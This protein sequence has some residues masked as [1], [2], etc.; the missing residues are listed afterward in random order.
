VAELARQGLKVRAIAEGINWR[1]A[2]LRSVAEKVSSDDLAALARIPSILELNLGSVPLRDG[3]LAS[4]AALK[5]LAVLH[6]ENTPIT[7]E[8]LAHLGRLEKLTYLNL[9]GTAVTD[10]G[11]RNLAGLKHLKWLYLAGTKVTG[12]GLSRLRQQLPNTLIESGAEFAEIAT[13]DPE[14]PNKPTATPPV[15]AA[16]EKP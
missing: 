11:L 8:G 2:D 10:A 13:K 4:I 7:D 16:A 9:F 1:R 5:N 3:D 6:L 14:P 12:P 15:K